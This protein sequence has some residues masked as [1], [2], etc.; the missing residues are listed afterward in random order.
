[1]QLEKYFH[2]GNEHRNQ[3]VLIVKRKLRW[4]MPLVSDILKAILFLVLLVFTMLHL[5]GT[6][7]S[8]CLKW[9]QWQRYRYNQTQK[10]PT[11]TEN[12]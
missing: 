1:M 3:L 5:H 4:S 7:L 12:T 11:V 8:G 9:Y 2:Q 10:R 6:N